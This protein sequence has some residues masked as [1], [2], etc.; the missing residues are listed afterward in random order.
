MLIN[1]HNN[2]CSFPIIVT[3][4]SQHFCK[5][6][7][8][9]ACCS[10]ISEIPIMLFL[11]NSSIKNIVAVAT[12]CYFCISLLLSIKFWLEK[13]LIVYIPGRLWTKKLFTWCFNFQKIKK[14]V[15]FNFLQRIEHALILNVCFSTYPKPPDLN[16]I[17][18]LIAIHS[19]HQNLNNSIHSISKL[20]HYLARLLST[21]M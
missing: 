2:F 21:L 7:F 18:V 9:S 20:A 12:K 5:W 19:K 10:L 17:S 15:I 1:Y 4:V 3:R 14:C 11:Q 16:C 8:L 6:L 13:W